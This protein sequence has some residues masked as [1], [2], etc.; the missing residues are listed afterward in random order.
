MNSPASFWNM[1]FSDRARAY[2]DEPADAE[3]L[4]ALGPDLDRHLVGRAAD[5]AGLD[6]HERLHVFQGLDEHLDWDPSAIL[7]CMI[8]IAL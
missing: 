6:L 8:S 1:V 7:F 4:P 2:C 5:P 3:R